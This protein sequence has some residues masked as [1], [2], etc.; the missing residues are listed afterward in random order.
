M[1]NIEK[2]TIKIENL[3][4]KIKNTLKHKFKN[5]DYETEAQELLNEIDGCFEGYLDIVSADEDYEDED[6]DGEE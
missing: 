6:E 2:L 4:E 1:S 3:Q 5:P